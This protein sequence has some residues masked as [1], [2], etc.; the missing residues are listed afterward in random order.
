MSEFHE[1]LYPDMIGWVS[2]CGQFHIESSKLS[3]RRGVVYARWVRIQRRICTSKD[4]C[5]MLLFLF[6]NYYWWRD[7]RRSA[8]FRLIKTST[9]WS[10]VQITT[11]KRL[12]P[13]LVFCCWDCFRTT[14]TDLS[15]FYK[16][17]VESE[18]H[19]KIDF[20]RPLSHIL[21]VYIWCFRWL[22]IVFRQ[23]SHTL[24]LSINWILNVR[25]HEKSSFVHPS[26][27]FCLSTYYVLHGFG[28]F[29]NNTHTLWGFYELNV[30][31]DNPWQIYFRTLLSHILCVYTWCSECRISDFLHLIVCQNLSISKRNSFRKL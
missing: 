27:T 21:P 16:F 18:N 9:F 24:V 26:H 13:R 30:E 25:I 28:L 31:C 19:W 10:G 12:R 4:Y 17:D 23:H 3:P 7:R 29:S 14:L 2:G 22:C 15:A 6:I 11:I 8:S 1:V 20:R 5:W